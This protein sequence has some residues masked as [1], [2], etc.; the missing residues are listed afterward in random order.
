MLLSWLLS[1]LSLLNQNSEVT[2]NLNATLK[3]I[4][5]FDDVS[6][7][8][9][10]F[11]ILVE[12]NVGSGKSSFLELMSTRSNV[13]VYQEPVELWRNVSGDNLFQKMVQ[14]PERWGA[15]FQLY[16]TQTRSINIL[17]NCKCSSSWALISAKESVCLQ[18]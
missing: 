6:K 16:S 1:A 5:E 18:S 13:E 15:T 3:S 7:D 17:F 10:P 14:Q 4:R 12:G 9:Q 2:N 11:L 8:D